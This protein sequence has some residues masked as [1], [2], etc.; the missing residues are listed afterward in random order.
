MNR[1]PRGRPSIQPSILVTADGSSTPKLDS[2]TPP[3]GP[4]SSAVSNPCARTTSFM[5]R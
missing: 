3:M 1:W 2:M 4:A 5:P